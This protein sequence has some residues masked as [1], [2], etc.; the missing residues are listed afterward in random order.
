M[1]HFNVL[2]SVL[3]P[4]HSNWHS[5]VAVGSRKTPHIL[6]SSL[7]TLVTLTEE[8]SHS[9]CRSILSDYLT[10]TYKVSK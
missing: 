1:T 7:Q 3:H 9:L 2:V 10:A 5:E 8:N 4:M 6:A